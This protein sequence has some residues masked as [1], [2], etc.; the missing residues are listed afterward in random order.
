LLARLIEYGYRHGVTAPF[1][2]NTPYLNTIHAS[3]QPPYPGDREIERRIKNLIR[4][5]AAAMVVQAN[6][7]SGGIGG[8]I[9]T[10]ASLATLLEVGFHHFFRAHTPEAAGDFVYF[11]GHAT[12]GV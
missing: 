4:W 12:P 7:H 9:S 6:K 1:T 3:A 2:A 5:N 10:Y 8:H 11:Q